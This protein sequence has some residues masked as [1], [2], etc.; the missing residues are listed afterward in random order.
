MFA[1]AVI[2]FLAMPAVVGIGVPLW[3]ASRDP[4][5]GPDHPAGLLLAGI[6]FAG[7]LWCVRDFYAIGKGTL[8]PWAP[9]RR[10]VVVGLYRFARNPMYLSV[11]TLVAGIAAW[12]GSP[13]T[14]A[15][16]LVLALVFHLRVVL[17]EEPVLA[18]SFPAEWAVYAGA[19][20]RWLPR[21]SPWR[22]PEPGSRPPA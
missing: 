1:R 4:S 10:L 13:T 14:L 22:G 2:A 5:R 12:R 15:Y 20:P 6:G 21:L 3:I 9:P 17:G 19:V 16:A 8:A 7:L 18:R 11:L